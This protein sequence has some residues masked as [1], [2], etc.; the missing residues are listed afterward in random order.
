MAKAKQSEAENPIAR[1]PLAGTWR[2]TQT[3]GGKVLQWVLT[4]P[5]CG[6]TAYIYEGTGKTVEPG[7]RKMEP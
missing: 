6:E 7:S 3:M 4:C 1:P 5:E 2:P